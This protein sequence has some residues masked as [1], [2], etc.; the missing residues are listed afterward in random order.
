MT[1]NEAL[2]AEVVSFDDPRAARLRDALSTELLARY[3]TE[4]FPHLSPAARS[5]L[6]VPPGEFIATVL[7]LTGDG[8]AVGHGAL[9]RLD[10]E[11]EVKR[12]VVL[13]E[14]RGK[15]AA[16]ILMSALEKLAITAGA[17]RLILQT[18]NKQPEAVALYRKLG[19]TPIPVYAPYDS[20]IPFSG[21]FEK[22][23]PLN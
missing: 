23:L 17:K 20:A 14:A 10:G 6:A 19:Y 12:V 2:H 9:R 3:A 5:A 4:E 1:R 18:G 13:P 7:V 22:L 8:T 15:G 21:C 16:S 11:F